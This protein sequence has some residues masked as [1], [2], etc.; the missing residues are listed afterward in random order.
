ML[1]LGFEA[2][3]VGFI[4]SNLTNQVTLTLHASR[5]LFEEQ[6]VIRK[7]ADDLK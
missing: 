3:W 5:K 1:N 4:I 2:G 7:I 6:G